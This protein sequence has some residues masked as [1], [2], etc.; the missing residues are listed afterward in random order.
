MEKTEYKGNTFK[1]EKIDDWYAQK[2]TRYRIKGIDIHSEEVWL[3]NE[4]HNHA[5]TE[6]LMEGSKEHIFTK[7]RR[8]HISAAMKYIKIPNNIFPQLENVQVDGANTEFTTDGRMLFT[9][10]GSELIYCL[11]CRGTAVTIPDTVKKIEARAF[12]GTEYEQ[13]QF[14]KTDMNISNF[15]FDN[16]RWLEKQG[17]TVVIGN[18]LYRARHIGPVLE[19]PKE[20]KKIHPGFFSYGNIPEKIISPFM[21]TQKDVYA[22]KR[23]GTC[24][25]LTI[26]SAY[27]NINLRLLGKMEDLEEIIITEGHK[28]YKSIDGVLF[29]KD[30]RTLVSY[31]VAKKERTYIIPNGVLKIGQSAFAHQRY[32]EKIEFPDSVKVIGAGAFQNCRDLSSVHLPPD[33]KE[34]PDSNAYQRGGVFEDCPCLKKITLPEKLVYLGSFAFYQSGLSS[35]ALNGKLEQIG[36]YALMAE[37]LASVSLPP[38]VKRLGKGSLFY[39]EQ[40]EAYEGTAKGLVAAVNAVFPDMKTKSANIEWKRCVVTVLRRHSGKR[41]CFLIPGSLRRGAA[42]HLDMAWN[43]DS[44]DYEEYDE[45]LSEI[46][47]SDEKLEFAELGLL[48]HRETDENPYIDYIRQVSYKLGYRL[49][50][51][52]KEKEFLTFLKQGFLSQNSLTRLLKF[53]NK[54][55]MTV[56]SAYIMEVQNKQARKNSSLRL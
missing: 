46:S 53:S 7:V 27:A 49:L 38:S 36:E 14:P 42:H 21:M 16:S 6:W 3:P 26:T 28:K 10:N 50:E 23:Y 55:G 12:S 25:S 13:I 34:I 45:C 31:P 4:Y 51:N 20:V 35:V 32:L 15:A 56:C 54:Q 44:I 29:S 33:I 48:R 8:L 19:V 37:K 40:L 5:V 52:R 30:G 47:E 17:D 41:E 43:S 9:K 24:R 11:V 22:I 18:M 1:L 39:A 2:H